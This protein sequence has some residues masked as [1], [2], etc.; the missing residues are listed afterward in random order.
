[1][2]IIG[3]GNLFEQNENFEILVNEVLDKIEG[4]RN[5][6]SDDYLQANKQFD[7]E[8][9][10]SRYFSESVIPEIL[11]EENL[12]LKKQY[13]CNLYLKSLKSFDELM[14]QIEKLTEIEEQV[15]KMQTQMREYSKA[16]K[17]SISRYEKQIIDQIEIPFFVYTSRFYYSH[18]REDKGV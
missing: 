8:G 3:I 13:L 18:I 7:F 4:T 9:I 5:E 11:T 6:I 14:I 2:E 10:T 15:N 16:L 12:D 17:S 1:M